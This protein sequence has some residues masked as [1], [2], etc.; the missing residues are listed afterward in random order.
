MAPGFA[1]M[2]ST[3]QLARAAGGGRNSVMAWSDETKIADSIKDRKQMDEGIVDPS[4]RENERRRSANT[5]GR[6][7]PTERRPSKSNIARAVYVSPSK[8]E[9][10]AGPPMAESSVRTPAVVEE[11]D[12]DFDDSDDDART[13]ISAMQCKRVGSRL[14]GTHFYGACR[15]SYMTGNVM[16]KEDRKLPRFVL[17][18][19]WCRTRLRGSPEE[20]LEDKY[21]F[22]AT[23]LGTR[24]WYLHQTAS[25][26]EATAG[27]SLKDG[28]STI[29]KLVLGM[30]CLDAPVTVNSSS[31]LMAFIPVV[32]FLGCSGNKTLAIHAL[33]QLCLLTSV[34]AFTNTPTRY[35][36]TRLISL[37]VRAALFFVMVA[38]LSSWGLGL[39]GM[40]MVTL[41]LLVVLADFVFG[42]FAQLQNYRLLCSY[43]VLEEL[44]NRLF[45]CRRT[46]AAHASD[47]LGTRDPVSYDVCGRTWSQGMALIADVHGILVE[48]HRPYLEELTS[49]YEEY[50]NRLKPHGFVALNIFNEHFP[51]YDT[52]NTDKVGANQRKRIV[53]KHIEDNPVTWGMLDINTEEFIASMEENVHALDDTSTVVSTVVSAGALASVS[54][55]LP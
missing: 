27:L 12:S 33:V 14:S 44:P 21:I 31:P 28:G 38:A 15:R 42:D 53:K 22:K 48:L 55:V 5:G 52:L 2:P 4:E 13:S 6:P 41:S 30:R 45:I 24:S 37:P 26:S 40:I 16:V 46:G 47:V 23:A 20:F 36:L 11:V 29:L 32:F 17:I 18:D 25:D 49:L 10:D 54:H 39:P 51:N 35:Q 8:E 19:L 9:A 3:V 34:S 50:Q 7:T 1:E 43:E